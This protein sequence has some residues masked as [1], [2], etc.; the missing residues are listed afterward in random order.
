MS[1]KN[2]QPSEK[3]SKNRPQPPFSAYPR[4]FTDSFSQP[5]VREKHRNQAIVGKLGLTQIPPEC[6]IVSITKFVFVC[7]S[8]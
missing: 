2:T 1:S 5:Y 6:I 4:K 8:R 7:A 3:T